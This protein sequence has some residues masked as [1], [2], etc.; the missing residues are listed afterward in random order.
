VIVKRWG[1]GLSRLPCPGWCIPVTT[2]YRDGATL[3]GLRPGSYVARV[4]PANLRK[5]RGR[6]A[7]VT[8]TVPWPGAGARRG[9]GC[10]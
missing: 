2:A 5:Y 7:K 1:R 6:G 8:F 3:T 10:C 9:G 4:G